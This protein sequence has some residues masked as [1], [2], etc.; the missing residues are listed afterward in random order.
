MFCNISQNACQIKINCYI[1]VE[2]KHDLSGQNNINSK[3][4]IT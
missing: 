2:N 4:L 1:A 3:S